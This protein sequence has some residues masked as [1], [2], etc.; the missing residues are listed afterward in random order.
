[1]LMAHKR[2]PLSVL[3]A[4]GKH[5]ASAP[6]VDE[7]RWRGTAILVSARNDEIVSA[8][9]MGPLLITAFML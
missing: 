5:P 7:N 3:T 9:A 8:R 6:G 2:S 4:V 1:M